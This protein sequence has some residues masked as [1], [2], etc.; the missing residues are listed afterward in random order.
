MTRVIRTIATM[1]LSVMALFAIIARMDAQTETSPS[2]SSLP[3][4]AEIRKILVNR[5]DV[6]RR[7]VGIVVGII[8]PQGR[9]I[10]TYGKRNQ[11]DPR[12]LTGDTIFEIGSVTKI[13]TSLLL[14]DMVQ[15]GEVALT[16]PVAKYLP[17]GVKTPDWRGHQITLVDL[18]TQT[19]GLPFFPTNLDAIEDPPSV[20]RYTFD[21][22]YAFLSGYELLRDV[23]VRW[24]YSNVGVGLLGHALSRRAGTSYEELVRNRIT[25]PLGMKSTGIAL[26]RSMK[27]RFATGHDGKLQPAPD[28]QM[29]V[30]AG[31]GALRSSAN[32]LLTFLGAFLGDKKSSLAPAMAAM[33]ETRR[34]GDEMLDFLGAEQALGW[35][36]LGKG[37]NQV[38][39]HGGDTPGFSSSVA[40]SPGMRTG[41]VVLSN[42][43][44]SG[45][46]LAMHLLRPSFP[47]SH[48]EGLPKAHKEIAVDPKLFDLYAGRYQAA[49][50]VILVI[51]RRGDTLRFLGPMAPLVRLHPESERH[52]FIAGSDTEITFDVDS[53]GHVTG[54][55]L[56]LGAFPVPAKRIETGTSK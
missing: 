19:S 46:D 24:E 48:P 41:V 37:N 33:L 2:V 50:N 18:A 49:P 54:L 1:L 36:V 13:F 43:A 40:Y 5:I 6:E 21:Q 25:G 23:G 39:G 47:L 14:A 55:T 4:D 44:N 11:G 38:M 31:A 35:W 7:S 45:D 28:L 27:A 15:R 30:L 8:T 34:L 3:T 52:Y 16:D 26:S 17:R 10:L 12:P 22:L 56:Q 9:R 29:P 32:D 51:E 53:N 42:T 20:A